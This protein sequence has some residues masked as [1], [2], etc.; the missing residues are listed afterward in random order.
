MTAGR[1]G[2]LDQVP[3]KL[4]SQKTDR[5]G[6]ACAAE[7]GEQGKERVG[8]RR[9]AVAAARRNNGGISACE[10]RKQAERPVEC[11]VVMAGSFKVLGFGFARPA[12]DALVLYSNLYETAA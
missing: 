3:R 10:V 2:R 5:R 9:G 1:K 8:A 6:W 11:P 12:K 4:T 7:G